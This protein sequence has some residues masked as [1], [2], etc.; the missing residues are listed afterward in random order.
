M[1]SDINV[2]LVGL[3]L[4][5]ASAFSISAPRPMSSGLKR[6]KTIVHMHMHKPAVCT[7]QVQHTLQQQHR[8]GT[9]LMGLFGL[10]WPEIAVIGVLSLLF[11]GPD[12]L[13]PIAKQLGQQAGGLKEVS[14]SF[15]DGMAEGT[16]GI[17]T[18]GGDGV[19]KSANLPLENENE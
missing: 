12:R 3:L 16:T 15:A 14:D 2:S 17:S 10:G 4:A 7:T 1:R 8:A 9:P 11:F 19:T 18:D 5:S 6:S 13:A